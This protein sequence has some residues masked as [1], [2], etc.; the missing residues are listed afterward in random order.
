M[1]FWKRLKYQRINEY[2]TLVDEFG[3]FKRSDKWIE[4]L[5]KY[6]KLGVYD[7]RILNI[8]KDVL[9]KLYTFVRKIPVQLDNGD[10]CGHFM[11]NNFYYQTLKFY[12]SYLI[13]YDGNVIE[14]FDEALLLISILG[15][16]PEYKSNK[17]KF[18]EYVKKFYMHLIKYHFI[19]ATPQLLNLRRKDGNLSSCNIFDMY[20]NLESIM[21][22]LCQVA[23]ISKRAGGIGIYAGRIRPSGSYLMGNVG[24]S[25][26]FN[27]WGKI[28]NDVIVAVNQGGMRKGSAT[29]A[30]PCW[31][32]DV[33]EFINCKNPLGDQRL[34][35]YDIF[36][37]II[38]NDVFMEAVINNDDWYLVDHY[39]IQKVDDSIDLINTYGEAFKENWEKVKD[40]IKN[41]KL[42]NYI[43]I[44]ARELIIEI[45]KNVT[46]SGL[47]YIFF[48]DAANKFSPFKEKIYCA[49]LCVES[50]SPFKNTNPEFYKL[51]DGIHEK[52]V[53]YAHSC[54]LFS[55]NLPR[56]YEDGIL[57]DDEKLEELMYLVVRYMDNIIDI[58]TP[59]VI[60]IKKHN[61]KYRTIGIGFLGLADLFVKY[62]IDNNTL[63]TYRFTT[64]SAG[65]ENTRKHLKQTLFNLIKKIFGRISFY[66]I[67][68][69]SRLAEERGV[70]SGYNS[71]KWKDG[72][73]LGR[74]NVYEDNIE[75]IFD[76][77][78]EKIEELKLKL[79]THGIR[80]CMLFN[81]PPNTST[82]IYAGTTASILPA[83]SYYQT[84]SQKNATYIVFP[85]YAKYGTLVYDFISTYDE[86]DVFDLVEI[87]AE[88][89]KYIDSGI[90]FEYPINH[91][92]IKNIPMF[93]YKFLIYVWKRNI[94]TLYYARNITTQTSGLDSKDECVACAN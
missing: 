62:S 54:N 51:H 73:I 53:G 42:K 12:K 55:L 57:F 48:E 65:N 15:F 35:L 76:V 59:P 94:K 43:K 71:T 50:F 18:V 37:Q 25:N 52:D 75:Q 64:R 68:S 39:E 13:R 10:G 93:F 1:D 33:I 23:Y 72:I 49:N 61:E 87:I 34:K 85:R 30:L 28:F 5:E 91:K 81:C 45:G 58:T 47:P 21:Y 16:Y 84:E 41:G 86:F 89:Q 79:K 70:P 88:I 63:I 38:L 82:S 69:S 9:R 3:F 46:A 31:H 20:D 44:K 40:L 77:P 2:N 7:K 92:K 60:E 4:H 80:N 8:S 56:L 36:P 83:Y 19:P 32:K 66:G 26:H 74:F 24:L 14:N 11:W 27:T 22:T 29:I 90:S 78:K 67:L 17:D 6:V